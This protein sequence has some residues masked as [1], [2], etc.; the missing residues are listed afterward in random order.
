M[1]VCFMLAALLLHTGVS[2]VSIIKSPERAAGTLVW[3]VSRLLSRKVFFF[4]IISLFLH[5][6]TFRFIINIL[7]LVFA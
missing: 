2:V 4:I 6:F 5:Y 3:G 7:V 1:P